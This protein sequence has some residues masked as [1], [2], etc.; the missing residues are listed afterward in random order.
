MS[1]EVDHCGYEGAAFSGWEV[2]HSGYEGAAFSGWEVDH[3]GYEGAAF[4]GWEVDH[5]GYEGAVP[6]E[7][8]SRPLWFKQSLNKRNPF[9]I[10]PPYEYPSS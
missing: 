1:W 3:S 7:L 5:S 2:D 8:G 10:K 6:S 4:S 9:L